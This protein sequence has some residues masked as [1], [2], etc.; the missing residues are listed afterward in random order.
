MSAPATVWFV[1]AGPGDPDLL[2]VRAQRLIRQADLLLYPGSLTPP[3]IVALAGR[4]ARTLDTAPLTLEQTH[5][6]ILEAA[7]DGQRVVR[8]QAGDPC[9]YGTIREQTRLL[10]AAGIPWAV[11][12]GVTS[13]SAAAAAAGISVTIPEGSQSL[14]LT[15]LTGRT[16][17]PEAQSLA[18]FAA[19]RCAMAVYLS[20]DAPEAVAQACR[21]GGLPDE[22][23]VVVAHRLGWPGERVLRTTVASMAGA[24]RA[25]GLTRQTLFLILPGHEDAPATRSRLYDPGFSHGFRPQED[26]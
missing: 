4:E 5:A 2:T 23:P 15:R 17:V 18:R 3:A 14:V 25:E 7:R 11:C 12:P 13:A 10:D 24:V 9:L 1:G 16:P 21:D 22:T 20:G 26:G 8:L 6:A 19:H